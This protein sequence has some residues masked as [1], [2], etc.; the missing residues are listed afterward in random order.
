MFFTPDRLLV[1]AVVITLIAVDGVRRMLQ[2]RREG[3]IGELPFR[4]FLSTLI[5]GVIL[6][7][8]GFFLVWL[9]SD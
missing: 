6:A 9:R 3:G 2:Q 1:L 7:W 5:I 4:I 8:F